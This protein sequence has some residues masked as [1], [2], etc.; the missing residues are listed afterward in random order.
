MNLRPQTIFD[1]LVVLFFAFLVWE[2][3]DWRLQARLYPWV[4]GV[5]MLVLAAAY[6]FMDLKGVTIKKRSG[7]NPVDFQFTKGIDPALARWRTFN[8]FSWIFGFLI[9]VWILGFSITIPLLTFLYLKVQSREGWI[10]TLLLTGST[11]LIFWGLFER[12]LR[13]PFPEGQIFLWKEQIF[14]WLGQTVL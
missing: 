9:G 13:L 8:I 3:K 1:L 4:I 10:L 6:L 11:W 7:E 12:M 14:R 5:P 2:A